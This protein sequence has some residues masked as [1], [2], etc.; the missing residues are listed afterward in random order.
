MAGHI[1]ETL[2]LLY[3]PYLERQSRKFS[4]EGENPALLLCPKDLTAEALAFILV[5]VGA[6][7]TCTSCLQ[8]RRP[9]QV[10]ENPKTKL[11]LACCSW[12]L[13]MYISTPHQSRQ[14]RVHC[15]PLV[16]AQ[17]LS[18]GPPSPAILDKTSSFTPTLTWTSA[19]LVPTAR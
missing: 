10:S 5:T 9:L 14:V 8:N 4:R 3:I 13:P 15:I 17:P 7:I 11:C 18:Q 2:F 12:S 1:S 19:L 6:E 16:L